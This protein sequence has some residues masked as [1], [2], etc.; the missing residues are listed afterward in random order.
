MKITKKKHCKFQ[1]TQFIK[2]VIVKTVIVKK[3]TVFVILMVENVQNSVSVQIALITKTQK[4]IK[5]NKTKIVD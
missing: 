3:D 2:A 4:K 1:R 5:T